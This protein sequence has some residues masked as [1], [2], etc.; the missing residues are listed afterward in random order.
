MAGSA[1]NTFT[2]GTVIKSS[3]VNAN[4][5]WL[6]GSLAP[7]TGGNQ[8]NGVY[9]LGT[10]TAAWRNLFLSN[11]IVL[12]GDTITSFDGATVEATN[13]VITVKTSGI[14]TSQIAANAVTQ[15][16]QAIDMSMGV[17]ASFSSYTLSLGSVAIT[18]SGGPIMI[19]GM[20]GWNCVST[21]AAPVVAIMFAQE[22]T[23]TNV[24]HMRDETAKANTANQRGFLSGMMI[25]ALAAGTYT[26]YL[27]ARFD[28]TA[29]WSI[30]N[31]NLA[32]VE[33]KK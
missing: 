17:F 6:E 23:T 4:F 15:Y 24:V 14:G 22:T 19:F 9:D 2:P 28:T 33:L 32:V 29:G 13:G 3:E 25:E 1:W 7:M 30:L 11:S 5:D 8:T 20:A 31:S 18:T 16:V 26:Y 27:R 21:S 12:N 10:T